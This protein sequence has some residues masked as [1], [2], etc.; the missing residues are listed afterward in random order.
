MA[1]DFLSTRNRVGRTVPEP[2]G[3]VIRR[4]AFAA[5][6]GGLSHHVRLHAVLDGGVHEVT[7]R[8]DLTLGDRMWP[9]GRERHFDIVGEH[10]SS[11]VVHVLRTDL[12]VGVGFGD[13]FQEIASS[14]YHLIEHRALPDHLSHRDPWPGPLEPWV[15]G[16][17]QGEDADHLV[18]LDCASEGP[19]T[20]RLQL[21]TRGGTGRRQA[22]AALT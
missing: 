13:R 11:P 18:A 12:R 21:W 22:R 2:T 15:L 14:V 1:T 4:E 7:R 17:D 6:F 9:D 5:R 16:P 8:W 19:R 20:R 10:V 3:L